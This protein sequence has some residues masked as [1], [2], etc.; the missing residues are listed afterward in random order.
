MSREGGEMGDFWEEDENQERQLNS[1]RERECLIETRKG[2]VYSSQ[3]CS[4]LLRQGSRT[5]DERPWLVQ[6][7]AIEIMWSNTNESA[8]SKEVR[9]GAECL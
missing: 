5:Q 8:I 7:T 6:R 2:L 3:L 9:S 4:D 1:S